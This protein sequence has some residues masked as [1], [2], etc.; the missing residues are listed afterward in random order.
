MQQII[1]ISD[2]IAFL[3][4]FGHH[5]AHH[6]ELDILYRRLLPVVLGALVIKLSV[7]CGVEGYVSGLQSTSACRGIPLPFTYYIKN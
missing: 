4:C 6:Q 2:F 1:F 3:T 5:Y 7:C